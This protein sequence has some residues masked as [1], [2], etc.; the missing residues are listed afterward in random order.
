MISCGWPDINTSFKGRQLLVVSMLNECWLSV[1]WY[2]NAE[3]T[4]KITDLNIEKWNRPTPTQTTDTDPSLILTKVL[5]S[6]T[7]MSRLGLGMNV[8]VSS[9][10]DRQM[11]RSCLDLEPLSLVQ[12]PATND[13]CFFPLCQQWN[14]FIQEK[15]EI[16]PPSPDYIFQS[17]SLNH[18][19]LWFWLLF[20][21]GRPLFKYNIQWPMRDLFLVSAPLS[22]HSAF[23]FCSYSPVFDN[24][25]ANLKLT[26]NLFL[27]SCFQPS[28]FPYLRVLKNI[29]IK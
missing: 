26:N 23:Q 12:I 4:S 10:T 6:T 11:T 16:F 13:T 27:A 20:A 7:W 5:V 1:L 14:H 29:P 21:W 18:K 3:P 2:S 9:W 8:S 28:W 15:A 17:I 22:L 19:I 24:E 25:D